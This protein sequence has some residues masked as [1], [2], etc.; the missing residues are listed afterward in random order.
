MA[1]MFL[2]FHPTT[3]G[4]HRILIFF[5]TVAG[6]SSTSLK[7]RGTVRLGYSNPEAIV[8]KIARSYSSLPHIPVS[9]GSSWV[10]SGQIAR[11]WFCISSVV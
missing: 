2:S 1:G 7:T 9:W 5:G 6:E 10:V 3:Q 8:C 4:Q 11:F